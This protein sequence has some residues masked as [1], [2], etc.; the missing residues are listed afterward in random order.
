M[1]IILKIF[2]EFVTVSFL[3]YISVFWPQGVWK[4]QLSDQELN[5]LPLHSVQFSSVQSLSRVQLFVTP[6]IAARQDSLSITN[7]WSLP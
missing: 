7:S 5:S 3:F 2:I 1:W 4:S 6:W